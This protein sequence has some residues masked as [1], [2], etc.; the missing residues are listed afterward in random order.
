METRLVPW[1]YSRLD[2]FKQCPKKFWHMNV[3]KDVPFEQSAA[4]KEGELQHKM[5]EDRVS[6]G[7]PIPAGYEPLE[8]IAQSVVRA[9]GKTFTEL[10]MALDYHLQPCGYSDWKNAYGRVIVDVLK[11]NGEAAWAGD[12]KTGKPTSDGLQLRINAAFLFAYYRDV[13]TVTTS[14]VWLKTRTVD[15]E[16]YTRADLAKMWSDGI[17]PEVDRLQEANKLNSW[18]AKANKF[19]A[20][21]PV[22]K[23]G[24]CDQAGA[25]ARFK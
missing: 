2:T 22:N 12:Y 1:S 10:K 13:D 14:Y 16:T 23:A 5:L 25:P 18:P 3:A 24:K 4:M 21:C 6:K 8:P 9:P 15:T 20:W 7:T 11:I 19:C 17:L